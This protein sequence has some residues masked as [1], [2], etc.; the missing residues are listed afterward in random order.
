MGASRRGRLARP[1][2][3]VPTI[4]HRPAGACK[5][6]ATGDEGLV[7]TDDARFRGVFA[8]MPRAFD[9]IVA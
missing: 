8:A 6:T 7:F 5:D 1:L 4:V 3:L 2:F 9:L